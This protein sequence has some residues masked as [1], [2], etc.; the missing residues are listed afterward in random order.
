MVCYV[1][2][3]AAY[4]FSVRKQISNHCYKYVRKMEWLTCSEKVQ[5]VYLNLRYFAF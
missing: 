4:I 1:L 3:D 2:C 5:N